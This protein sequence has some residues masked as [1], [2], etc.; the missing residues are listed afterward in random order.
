VVAGPP[1][2]LDGHS[3]LFDFPM[4]AIGGDDGFINVGMVT[5]YFGPSDWAPDE[6]HGTIQPFG[7]VP[8]LSETPE[9]GNV[10]AGGSQDV[11]LHLG[12]PDLA[13]GI[14]HATVVFVTNAPKQQQVPVDVTLTVTLP[15]EF[16]AVSGTV[17]NAHT[18][19][20]LGGVSVAIHATWQGN[21]LDLTTTTASDGTWS[22]V[23]PEGTWSTDFTLD[24]YVPVT[25][26]VTIVRGVTTPGNDVALHRIQPHA[27]IDA[28]SFT[29]ILTPDRTDSETLTLSNPGGHEDL[30]F[31][32]GEVNLDPSA[33][34]AGVSVARHLPT[35]AN[36]SAKS[37]KGLFGSSSA[38]AAP[39]S[40]RAD[41][42]V[43]A[44]WNAGMTLPWGVGYTGDVYLSDPFDLID[45][46]FQTDGTRLADFGVPWAGDWA[47]DM[48][49]DAGRQ[50]IWQV[51]VGG[52]NGIY[53]L[54]PTDGTVVD[55]ITGSPWDGI[56]QRGLAYDHGSDV[57]YI[58]GWNEG[59]IYRVAGP[60][61]PTPGETLSQCNPPDPNISGLAW[62]SSFG[63]LWEATNSDTDAIFLIDPATCDAVRSLPHPDGGGF[64]GA[65]IEVDVVGN[66]WTVGQNSGN[67]YLIESGLPAFSDVPWLSVSPTVGT[68]PPDGSQELTITADSTGLEPGVYRAIVVVQTNDPDNSNIQVPVTLVVPTYQQGIDTGAGTYTDPA[69]GNF[70]ASDRAFAAGSFGYVGPSSTRSTGADIA[71][72]TRDPLYQDLRTGMTAYRFSVPNGTYRVDLSFAELQ[73]QKANARV[74]GVSLEGS[75]VLSNFDVYASAGGRYVALDRSFLVEVTDG[76]LDISFLA[77]RGDKPIIN[78][79]LV[80]EMPPGSPGL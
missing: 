3:V 64:G 35:G 18:G 49:F 14:Y 36:P 4:D 65:G 73:Y 48:A 54:D 15:D 60:S 16:G 34:V 33:A 76:V 75:A 6:G 43:L 21:P 45:V 68:V 72:T 5:G 42:D 46:Q 50:L 39:P 11:T 78:G 2:T 1:P 74:F 66:L 30:T 69:N 19:D 52:D 55:S 53:G 58:G 41:G 80:T 51:N 38:L 59:I 56:S 70:Y 71:G 13:P 26:D 62:N 63:L 47:G 79:I 32:I 22:L 40:I 57:F 27:A 77:Q 25:Q 31:Q 17:T 44:S 9:S 12:S 28:D 20:P 8:W 67:A 7:D 29:F 24:G 10:P 37:T 61:W 23:G